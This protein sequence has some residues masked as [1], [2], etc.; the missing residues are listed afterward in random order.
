MPRPSCESLSADY[1]SQLSKLSDGLPSR[2][3]PTLDYLTSRLP[4]LFTSDWPLVPNHIDLLE[5]N[6]HVDPNTGRLMGICDWKDTEVS[7]FGMSLG[8][9]ETML[10]TDSWVRG[11]CYHANQQ[12]LRALFWETFW[13]AM[14]SVSEEQKERIEI[15]RLVGLFLANGFQYDDDGN[16]VPA[17][18]GYHEL[19]YLEAVVLG[20]WMS[21]YLPR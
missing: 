8:G 19:R 16:L 13:S 17:S 21:V 18:E 14:G 1:S 9:L 20:K 6:I 5:N 4:G 7:P 2:F 12:E 3:R 11:W 15:A 10:G